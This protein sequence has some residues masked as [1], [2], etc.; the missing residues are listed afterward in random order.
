MYTIVLNSFHEGGPG[1]L[2]DAIAKQTEPKYR[3]GEN[4]LGLVIITKNETDRCV[5]P[6]MH[7]AHLLAYC[8]A[9]LLH[10]SILAYSSTKSA[11]T[12][13]S[14]PRTCPDPGTR[15]HA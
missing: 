5:C 7:V 13:C 1:V 14:H 3:F 2:Q 9:W 11:P 6:K 8:H 12:L 10:P 15:F 4:I